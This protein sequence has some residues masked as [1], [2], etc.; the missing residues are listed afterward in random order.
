MGGGR[1]GGGCVGVKMEVEGNGIQNTM[2][3][4]MKCDFLSA[5][6]PICKMSTA[7]VSYPGPQ[8]PLQLPSHQWANKCDSAFF[9]P[10]SNALPDT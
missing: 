9:H 2:W 3:Y 1:R 4:R 10:Q 5:Q 7:L 6:S 8:S